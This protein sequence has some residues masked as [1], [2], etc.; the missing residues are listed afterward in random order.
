MRQ[1]WRRSEAA[2]DFM[3]VMTTILSLLDINFLMRGY[4]CF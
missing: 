4:K 3:V 1:F 2:A